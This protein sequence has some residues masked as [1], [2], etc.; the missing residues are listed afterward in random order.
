M[1]TRLLRLHALDTRRGSAR[2]SPTPVARTTAV[3]RER[4]DK[5]QPR[6]DRVN[7]RIRETI[8]NGTPQAG[9]ELRPQ[10]RILGCRLQHLIDRLGEVLEHSP[11][12]LGLPGKRLIVFF[13]GLWAPLDIHVQPAD[14]RRFARSIISRA[15]RWTSE[16]GTPASLP[17]WRSAKRRFAS[18]THSASTSDSESDSGASKLSTNVA[19]SWTRSSFGSRMASA[20]TRWSSLMCRA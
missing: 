16:Y 3:M 17:A 10:A 18:V 14:A 4:D 8:E 15:R 1:A 20:M 7:Q 13:Y 9:L 12:V 2:D 6:L 5:H 19:T 11:A